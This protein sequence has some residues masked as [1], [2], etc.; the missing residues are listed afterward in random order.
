MPK[1]IYKRTEEHKR[2][3]TEQLEI[4]RSFIVRPFPKEHREKI[5]RANKGKKR[6]LE[7]RKRLSDAHKGQRPSKETRK[8]ISEGLTGRYCSEETRKKIGQANSIV[9][10]GKKHSKESRQKR[11]EWALSHPEILRR[12]GALG[13]KKLTEMNGPTSIE[14]KVYDELKRRGILFEEQRLI[15]GRFFVDAFI[16]SLN[17]V[18]EADGDYWHSLPKQIGRDKSRNAY[19]KKCGFNLLRLTGTEIRDDSFKEKLDKEIN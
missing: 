7:T 16:P 6:S 15:N 18:I 13:R 19:L 10:K 4:A 14:K 9:L 12:N 2:K 8:K 1:G 17:L 3:S 11:R 5:G